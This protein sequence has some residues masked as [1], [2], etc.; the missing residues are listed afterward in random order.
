MS[1]KMSVVNLCLLRYVRIRS[2]DTRLN[3]LNIWVIICFT[4]VPTLP[5]K[6]QIN[7]PDPG[8][9]TEFDKIW[10][11]PVKKIRLEQK[12]SE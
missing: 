12:A 11:W 10:K 2:S 8:N 1:K 3:R 6:H 4:K 5:E 9:V 7:F